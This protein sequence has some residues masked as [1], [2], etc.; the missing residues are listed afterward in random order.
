MSD[1]SNEPNPSPMDGG[2][3][4]S[5]PSTT[6][7]AS[8][9][10]ATAV[11]PNRA[12]MGS[13]PSIESSD[14]RPDAHAA[15]KTMEGPS[16]NESAATTASASTTVGASV[17]TGAATDGATTSN[18]TSSSQKQ[19]RQNRRRT[20]L[21][22]VISGAVGATAIVCGLKFSGLLDIPTTSNMSSA[23]QTISIRPS[24]E[25]ATTAQ[26]VS[27][28]CLPSV[29][30]IYVSSG[31][32]KYVG[33][34]V[35]LDTDGNIL[36]NYHVVDG[37]QTITVT[38]N[39]INYEAKV[40]GSDSSSDLAVLKIDPKGAK[41]TPIEVGDSSA[42]VVGDW[43]MSIGSPYGLD[44]S[45]SSGIVSSLYRSTMLPS[46]SGNTIYANL[47]QTDAAINPGNSGGALVN[48]EGKLVGIN[49]IIESQSGASAG[50]GFAIPSNYAVKVAKTI[51]EGKQVLHAYL[52]V[53]LQTVTA[54]NAARS[55]LSV[56]QGAYVMNVTA[57]SPA[58]KAGL[59][60]G[61]VITK[62]NDDTISSADALILAVRSHEVGEKVT[63]T[64]MRGSEEKSF[65]V[66]LG[67]DE[68][69]QEAA[70]SNT[71]QKGD[72]NNGSNDGTDPRGQNNSSENRGS[73]GLSDLL[74]NK[75]GGMI[76]SR[77]EL[78]NTILA[79]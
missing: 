52:G 40:V 29:A 75:G 47:I 45:V 64:V 14:P 34:G 23:G 24:D 67:S 57:D 77:A 56:N 76:A 44:Q 7:P 16:I 26:A 74:S 6:T 72:V 51:I 59:Q 53:S 3:T 79:I 18:E 27:K 31:N 2:D 36:T 9:E 12:T 69:L 61:D 60:E 4:A 38:L 39:N 63:V 1:I 42:L 15:E 43:V 49:S 54:D 22:S 37:A 41:L 17:P 50:I 30:S 13:I 32:K 48:A 11:N 71:A 25:K 58:A 35:V 21:I 5:Q 46:T 8:P 62:V 33:S 68:S 28:K 70:A 78:S 65:E 19:N 10:D 73:D 20:V 66:T 55:K